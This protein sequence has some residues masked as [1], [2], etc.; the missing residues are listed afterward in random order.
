MK[1]PQ[2]KA[3]RK[4]LGLTQMKMCRLLGVSRATLAR[5]EAGESPIPH[6]VEL[7][8][9]RLVKEAEEKGKR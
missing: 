8:V 9:P 7:L 5:W 6:A 1:G 4:R 3:A 2:M